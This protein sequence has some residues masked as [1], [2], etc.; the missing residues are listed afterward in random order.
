M[1][2]RSEATDAV[3]FPGIH[4]SSA[5]E[6]DLAQWMCAGWCASKSFHDMDLSD[7]DVTPQMEVLPPRA[8]RTAA[9]ARFCVLLDSTTLT[10]E[11]DCERLAAFRED[12]VSAIA[13]CAGISSTRVRFLG[14]APPLGLV[15]RRKMSQSSV[16]DEMPFRE[17]NIALDVP[18]DTGGGVLGYL[19]PNQELS[20]ECV[21]VSLM[22][23]H[24]PLQTVAEEAQKCST[25]EGTGVTRVLA[26][27]EDPDVD[28]EE[29]REL[30]ALQALSVIYEE[31]LNPKSML[32]ESLRPWRGGTAAR[33]FC[34]SGLRLDF[35]A[36]SN[37]RGRAQARRLA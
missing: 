23:K 2:R 7:L 28:S 26:A 14:V 8:R 32:Q 15:P 20:T 11:A 27:I 13:A 25:Y 30:S 22:T 6:P 34:P 36:R 5:S 21:S 9:T 1:L 17:E 33:F 12:F 29:G 18:K 19:V 3:A 24:T 31:L 37:A 4:T 10:E 35:K 16:C